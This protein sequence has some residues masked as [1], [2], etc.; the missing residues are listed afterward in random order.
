MSASRSPRT[1]K[2]EFRNFG[3]AVY[4]GSFVTDG[5]NAPSVVKGKGFTVAAPGTGVYVITFDEKFYGYVAAFVGIHGATGTDDGAY[6]TAID[7]APAA[8]NATLTVETQ[9][10]LGTAANLT[11]PIVSFQVEWQLSARGG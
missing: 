8:T 2:R 6:W 3:S 5:A 10:A 9:S 4:S 7:P 11:G 1:V